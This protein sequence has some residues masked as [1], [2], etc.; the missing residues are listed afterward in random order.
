MLP[1]CR[2]LSKMDNTRLSGRIVWGQKCSQ[3]HPS[4][5][6]PVEREGL[7]LDGTA[8]SVNDLPRANSFP[9]V[10]SFSISLTQIVVDS[11]YNSG[12]EYFVKISACSL[13]WDRV[14]H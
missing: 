11:N 2:I 5:N 4:Y 13:T 7:K 1:R 9:I 3:R 6:L 10:M 12:K 8:A 14:C